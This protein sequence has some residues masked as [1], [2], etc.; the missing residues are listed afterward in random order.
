[1]GYIEYS[2]FLSFIHL[3]FT[4]ASLSNISLSIYFILR[5][6]PLPVFLE[7]DNALSIIRDAE[8]RDKLCSVVPAYPIAALKK[9]SELAFIV[10][11]PDDESEQ[12]FKDY[13]SAQSVST[14][15]R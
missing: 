2:I 11:P 12:V 6:S 10:G 13:V 14:Y 9:K 15:P 1:M 5:F 3:R 4:F 7:V 8:R